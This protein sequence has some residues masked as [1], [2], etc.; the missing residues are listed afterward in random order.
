MRSPLSMANA[1]WPLFES[2]SIASLVLEG[3]KRS[4]PGDSTGTPAAGSTHLMHLTHARRQRSHHDCRKGVS[5]H[6]SIRFRP[7]ILNALLSLATLATF[8][9][10]VS[11][12]PMWSRRY[13][14]P[15]SYCHAFPGLQL[16]SAGID[17][18]RRGHRM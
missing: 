5:M 2:R 8:V 15:C 11:A 14:V 13:S 12:I 10:P 1:A 4:Y 18:F 3:T 17:F 16:T 7:R 6:H 9:A